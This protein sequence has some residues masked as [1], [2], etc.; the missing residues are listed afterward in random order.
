[1][2]WEVTF[3]PDHEFALHGGRCD[4]GVTADVDDLDRDEFDYVGRTLRVAWLTG[5]EAEQ[6][7]LRWARQL[8][9]G[10][11]ARPIRRP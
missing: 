4:D 6:H 2:R 8:D 11:P 3:L 10:R 9:Q 7:R 5:R 1:V